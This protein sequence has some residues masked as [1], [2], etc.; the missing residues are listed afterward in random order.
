MREL[1]DHTRE[2]YRNRVYLSLSIS[3]FV[4]ILA[5]IDE[6]KKSIYS[7]INFGS[8]AAAYPEYNNLST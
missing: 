1:L 6:K 4:S 5:T 8:K 2:P 7:L 3:I